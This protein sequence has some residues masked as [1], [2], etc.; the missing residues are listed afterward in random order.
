M[1]VPENDAL[2]LEMYTDEDI[3]DYTHRVNAEAW[4]GLL[5]PEE[6]IERERVLASTPLSKK[7]RDLTVRE[8]FPAGYEWVG[9][10]YFV[11]KDTRLPNTSKTSQIVSSCETLNSLGYCIYPEGDPREDK[12]GKEQGSRIQYCLNVCIGGVFTAK[13]YRGRG[14]AG[15]MI[16]LLNKFYEH[17]RDT[18]ESSSLLKNLVMTLYSEVKDYYER[19][20]YIS[21]HVPLH[22]IREP[23]FDNFVQQYCD[24]GAESGEPLGFDNYKD[25]VKLQDEQV[26]RDLLDCHRREPQAYV[27]TV[28]PDFDKY[29]WFQHR[30]VFI[31]EKLGRST[32]GHPSFGY[33]LQDKSHIIWHHHWSENTL[34]ILKVYI[35]KEI[36]DQATREKKL[37]S[38]LFQAIKEAQRAKLEAIEF[39]DEEIRP[40]KLPRLNSVLRSV[41]DETDLYA[42]NG[43]LSAVK[44]PRGIAAD[45]IIWVNNAKASWF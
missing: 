6:Y 33:T 30:D 23:Q 3:V 31:M 20:G 28:R 26:K 17:I 19:V 32:T 22:Y 10:K 40:D 16:D 45:S 11:L 43:S 29:Q 34:I 38:L 44:P 35:P 25:L 13:R 21:L 41:C 4:R 42:T 8:K 9:L 12:E 1:T 7:H 27:F 37:G 24:K 18:A 5:S 2:K 15:A 36:K 14:Y 39:W